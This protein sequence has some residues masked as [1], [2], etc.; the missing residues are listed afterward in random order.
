MVSIRLD[1][2]NGPIGDCRKGR[3]AVLSRQSRRLIKFVY[4]NYEHGDMISVSHLTIGGFF[5]VRGREGRHCLVSL[6]LFFFLFLLS[7]AR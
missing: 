6:S 7:L 5:C 1:A 2:V 3:D 4:L